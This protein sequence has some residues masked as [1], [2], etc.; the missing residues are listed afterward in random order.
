MTTAPRGSQPLKDAIMGTDST[1][2]P[3]QTHDLVPQVG[4]PSPRGGGKPLAPA[5]RREMEARLGHSFADV[6]VHS[7]ASRGQRG[8]RARGSC[9]RGRARPSCS[10]PDQFSLSTPVAGRCSPMSS[11]TWSSSAARGKTV[12]RVRTPKPSTAGRGGYWPLRSAADAY[13]SAC[14]SARRAAR[15]STRRPP[16]RQPALSAERA[17]LAMFKEEQLSFARERIVSR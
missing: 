4:K 6:R 3:G 5:V 12:R 9:V 11:R 7:G 13:W 10:V 2:A 17:E 15:G 8:A 16:R 14:C 1:A